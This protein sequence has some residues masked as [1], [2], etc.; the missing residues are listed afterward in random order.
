[1]MKKLSVRVLVMGLG[2]ISLVASAQT[3]T[4][5]PAAAA[6]SVQGVPLDWMVAVVN[7]DVILESDVNED[8]RLTAFQP[9]R[10]GS[11]SRQQ[12]I[13]RLINRSL[14][15]QQ[16]RLQPEKGITDAQV[17]EQ[18][19]AL[20]KEISACKQ[21]QCETE[22]GWLKFIRDQ[23]FTLVELRMRWRERMEVLRFIEERFRSGTTVSNEDI[24]TYYEKTM[25]PQYE[26]MRATPPKLEVISN[27]IQ[28]IL[29]QQ[30]VGN[31]LTDWLKSLRAQGTV[32]TIEAENTSE[33]AK[34]NGPTKTAEPTKETP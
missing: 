26:R 1:M 33:P 11:G 20:R 3:A 17:D 16:A 15:L 21:Y 32:R 4:P 2:L 29:L 12:A 18:L 30:Q 13:E 14:I 27:R 22:A 5:T 34:T 28:E 8:L 19:N 6:A 25:L 24:R 23:D 31:L 7:G 10:A 9:L